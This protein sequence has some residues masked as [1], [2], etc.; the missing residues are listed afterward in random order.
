MMET[1]LFGHDSF[2]TSSDLMFEFW[3]TQQLS[4]WLTVLGALHHN[5]DIQML[6]KQFLDF[7]S[8]N[9]K[10]YFIWSNAD[11]L[12]EKG[13]G[14]GVLCAA[15]SLIGV[16]MRT[17]YLA[18]VRALSKNDAEALSAGG[19]RSQPLKEKKNHYR[20]CVMCSTAGFMRTSWCIRWG[21]LTTIQHRDAFLRAFNGTP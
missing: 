17:C 11:T 6:V 13:L 1:E 4:R 5:F 14:Q 16:Q 3:C 19:E 8:A 9:M 18:A 21:Y 2:C 10:L 15:D 20:V 12:Y 7:I